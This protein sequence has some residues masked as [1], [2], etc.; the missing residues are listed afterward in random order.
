MPHATTEPPRKSQELLLALKRGITKLSESGRTLSA[1]LTVAMVALVLLAAT[2]VGML[3]YRNVEALVLPR[4]LDR[5]DTHTRLL[6][7]E[8]EASVRGARANIIGFGSAV[9]IDGIVRATLGGGTDPRDGMTV[10]T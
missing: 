8:L 7:A 10:I 4:A 2:T 6:A 3:T 1:R 5:L 9:A